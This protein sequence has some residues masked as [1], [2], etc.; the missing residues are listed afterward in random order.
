MFYFWQVSSQETGTA[1][2]WELS[3]KRVA[4]PRHPFPLCAPYVVLYGGTIMFCTKHAK[5]YVPSLTYEL[6]TFVLS[7]SNFIPEKTRRLILY[8]WNYMI[9]LIMSKMKSKK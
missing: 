6:F 4:M 3:H 2:F 8:L 1:V 5:M 7:T 9:V